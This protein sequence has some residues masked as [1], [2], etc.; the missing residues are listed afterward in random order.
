MT[1]EPVFCMATISVPTPQPTLDL[2]SLPFLQV[3]STDWLPVS[4]FF[5]SKEILAFLFR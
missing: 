1:D 4:G 2:L 3:F 5:I